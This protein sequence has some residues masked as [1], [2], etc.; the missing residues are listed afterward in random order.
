MFFSLASIYS[1][2]LAYKYFVF[3]PITV[4]E[5]PIITIIAGFLVS[6]GIFNFFIAY[7]VAVAGDLA[8]DVIHYAVGRFG[9]LPF[10]NKWGC[11]FHISLKQ[12]EPIERQFEERGSTL[13]F[14]GKMTHG[15]GGAFLVAAGLIKMPFGKFFFSNMLAT[16]LKSLILLVIGYYF[17]QAFVTINS[18]LEKIAI[19]TMAVAVTAALAYLFYHRQKSKN[20]SLA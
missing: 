20:N 10:I 3:F 4:I 17:G 15:I 11:F 18:Y 12:L 1:W 6:I 14:I 19:L 5:G 13:L 9:G 8:G 7:L 2:L 16:L